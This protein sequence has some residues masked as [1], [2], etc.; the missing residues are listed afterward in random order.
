VAFFIYSAGRITGNLARTMQHADL[1][2]STLL[3]L[4]AFGVNQSIELIMLASI[5][6]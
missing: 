1:K 2:G 6:T 3:S 5:F 4:L